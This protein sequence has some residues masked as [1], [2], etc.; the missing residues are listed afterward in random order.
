MGKGMNPFLRASECP[1]ELFVYYLFPVGPYAADVVGEISVQWNGE[2]DLCT[3]G[4]PFLRVL[5]ALYD[6]RDYLAGW[7]RLFEPLVVQFKRFGI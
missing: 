2:H 1:K 7:P 5:I 4:L 6:F 3:I